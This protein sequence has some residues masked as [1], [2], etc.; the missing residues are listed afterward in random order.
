MILNTTESRPTW[1]IYTMSAFMVIG[2]LV[3]LSALA[4][5]EVYQLE[6]WSEKVAQSST[7]AAK[8]PAPRGL[9]LDRNGSVLVDNRPSYN[10][11][12]F[13][14]EFG[15]GRSTKK[16][17]RAVH[18]SVETLKQR[19]KMPVKVNDNTVLRH[20]DQR[21][22]LPL[23]VWNDLS[24]TALAAF[25]ERSPWMQG[26]DLQIEPV[27]VYPFGQL[28]SHI[29]GYVGKPE[30]SK[31]QEEDFD[32]LGRRA[33]SQPSVVGKS[34]IEASM[35]KVLQGTPGQ[36]IIKLSAA[37]LKEAEVSS[38][39]PT[40]GSN[41]ILTLDKDIQSIVEETFT[42]HRG[43]CIVMDPNTGDILAMA[44]APSFNPNQ[45]IPAIKSSDW[46][47]LI[48]NR[49][50]PLINRAIQ[51]GYAP[52]SIYKVITALAGLEKGVIS[53][54]DRVECLG[55]FFLGN[56]SFGCWNTGG[57]GDMDLMEAMTQSCDVYFYTMGLKTGG[58]AMRDMSASFGL[59]ERTGIPLDHEDSGLLPDEEWK[60]KKNPRDR[61]TPGDS[62]NM[63]IGQGA[64]LV[65]PLQMAVVAATMANGGTVYKPRLVSRIESSDGEILA[66]FPP[67]TH[68][69]IPASPEHIDLVR[70]TMLNV[71]D[72]G[73]GKSAGIEKI[74]IAG[75]TGSAQF[76][77]YDPAT[78]RVTKQT[79]AW[80]ITFA[81]YLQPRYAIVL[82][83]EATKD[84]S[85]GHTAGP[86]IG[87][88]Y[89]KIFQLEQD[90]KEQ[91]PPPAVVA[92]PIS[93]KIEGFEG[94]V[95][96][97][98]MDDNANVPPPPVADQPE[99]EDEPPPSSFPAEK[100]TI[101]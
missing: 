54:H 7:R 80:M 88:I 43:A 13:L 20:Y 46:N 81:P 16:L 40:A 73:T 50:H 62:V 100:V 45:F 34:G 91:K 10:V 101:P 69:L 2:L 32:S 66:D 92:V 38:S 70:K 47:A 56:I 17:L 28:A 3:L 35:D 86:Y 65:T 14:D 57:H 82:V 51:G 79:R 36:R 52:G 58:P 74:K 6:E 87:A 94:D 85:G 95:S 61:W 77:G 98:L 68:G 78:D 27:R 19:M 49:E 99:D 37:G 12:L 25:E 41:V 5:R 42:G 15:A 8:I 33:F 97:E 44:S 64:L 63:S 11:A 71:V 76:T 39:E 4:Y 67:E 21:G 22:P 89:K 9:I 60:R 93:E 83:A 29:L 75:K 26:V 1:R 90:R 31:E 55:R 84:E 48:R 23:T 59:G 18:S 96:G 24:P 30:S 53:P 72:N